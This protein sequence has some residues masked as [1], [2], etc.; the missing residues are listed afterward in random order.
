MRTTSDA[1]IQVSTQAQQA[2]DPATPAELLC[3][4]ARTGETTIRAAIASNPVTVTVNVTWTP[5]G[6][7]S[8]P[9]PLMV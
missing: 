8:G 3:A 1:T 4:L 9:R 2:A 7:L 5:L 6:G